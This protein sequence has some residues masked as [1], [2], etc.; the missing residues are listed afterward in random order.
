MALLNTATILPSETIYSYVARLHGLWGESNYRDTAFRWLGKS[1][2]S[3]DQKLPVGLTHLANA[4]NNDPLKLLNEHTFFP[5]FAAHSGNPNRLGNAL[6]CNN[7]SP[8]GNLSNVSQSGLAGFNTSRYCP[9]CIEVDK[10]EYGVAYW[11]LEHQ[12]TGV[13]AC[14]THGL[15]LCY[16]ESS[17]RIFCLPPQA[18]YI[19]RKLACTQ[20]VRFA[21]QV[22]LHN[23]YYKPDSTADDEI[24][25]LESDGLVNQKNWLKGRSTNMDKLM[26]AL[27]RTSQNLFSHEHIL[28]ET[29]VRNL[30]KKPNYYGHPLKPIFLNFVLE[31]LPEQSTK[32]QA[33]GKNCGV[34]SKET[35]KRCKALLQSNQYS[36]REISRRLKCS[37]GYVKALAGRLDANYEKRTQFITADIESRIV[38]R[39]IKGEGRI[40]IAESESVSIGA[41]EQIIQG[42]KDLSV[43]R[44]YLRML[45]KRDEARTA[46]IQSMQYNPKATRNELKRLVSAHYTW[47]YKY[48]KNWLYQILPATLKITKKQEHD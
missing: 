29:V 7:G 18:D 13:M 43:Y 33:Q 48:D 27:R 17:P 32:R 45:D 19:P 15:L 46:L 41:V 2:A 5:I 31:S 9:A 44:Q 40:I 12:F 35:E 25:W 21:N 42:V 26:D 34:I 6:L 39:A 28:S 37:M 16:K 20:M 30:L 38:R 23:Q 4:S 11:H 1:S 14:V 10:H 22:L 36:L 8:V 3:V 47:L 24:F